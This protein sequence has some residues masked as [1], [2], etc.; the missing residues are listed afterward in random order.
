MNTP[1]PQLGDILLGIINK[2][3]AVTSQGSLCCNLVT[4]LNAWGPYLAKRHVSSIIQIMKMQPEYK[5]FEQRNIDRLLF[6]FVKKA[7]R[8][9]LLDTRS[10]IS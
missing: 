2:H 6:L 9:S 5:P 1:K 4:V 3:I 10:T 8:K 7:I